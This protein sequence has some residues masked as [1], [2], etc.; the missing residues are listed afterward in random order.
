MKLMDQ[1]MR[2][3]V[4]VLLSWATVVSGQTSSDGGSSVCSPAI[5]LSNQN[6]S[7]S[8]EKI[9][10]VS[11]YINQSDQDVSQTFVFT[12]PLNI[13][14]DTQPVQPQLLQHALNS[15]GRDVSA[16]L[17][18][19][20][21][22]FDPVAA[23]Q[24]I[25]AS[26]NR[27]TMIS[28]LLALRL[29]DPKENIP[30]WIAQTYYYWQYTF[31]A[32]QKTIVEYNYKPNIAVKS[33]KLN[34]VASMLKAPINVMKK[35][36]NMAVHWTLEDNVAANNLQEQLEKYI[37]NIDAYC[38]GTEDYQAIA[39]SHRLNKDQKPLIETRA[40]TFKYNSDDLWAKP[41]D[42]FTLSIDSSDNMYPVL[43]WHDKLQREVNNSIYFSAENYVPMQY[44][45]VLY[46]EK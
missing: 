38:L 39:L 40:L 23:M 44:I 20:G 24:I 46:I 5:I 11:E 8:S 16:Q 17:Q 7:I 43:C 34:N 27:D 45:S 2:I 18:S 25:D 35:A 9:K 37:A 42:K 4:L 30:S 6:I 26:S 36:V 12:T 33:V 28:K 22:P 32:G 13:S 19:L 14:V 1:A 21:L 15:D 3:L 29:I 10:V 31:Q 41:L